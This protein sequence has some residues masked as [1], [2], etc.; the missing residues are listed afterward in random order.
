MPQ[1]STAEGRHARPR[2]GRRRWPGRAPVALALALGLVGCSPALDWRQ[3]RPEG[4]SLA[5][6]LPCRPASHARQVPLAGAPVELLLLACSADGHTFAVASADL[7]DPARVGP[8]LQALAAAALANVAGTPEA[9]RPAAVAGMTPHPLARHLLLR[10]RLPDGT[11]VREQVLVFS[12]GPRVF[13]ASV[14]G[15]QADDPRSRP[16]F[17]SIVV[18][19]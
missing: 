3:V 6:S 17:D 10:G 11:A 5:V 19:R 12:L 9:E 16:F 2:A 15:P 7:G 14:V 4:W 18:L 13:Q 8:A 1:V